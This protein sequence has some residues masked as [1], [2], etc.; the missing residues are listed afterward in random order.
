[1]PLVAL[2]SSKALAGGLAFI[3]AKSPLSDERA[4]WINAV[5]VAPEC[6]RQGIGRRLIEAAQEA[7]A[8]VGI[9][10]LYALT[11]LPGL[12]S[13]LDWSTVSNDGVDFVMTWD[14]RGAE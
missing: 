10:R 2:T 14:A 3:A 8:R 1:M 13:K 9:S 5:L 4:V 12:Y 11:E 7:A 6:R